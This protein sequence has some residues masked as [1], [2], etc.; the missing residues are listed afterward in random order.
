MKKTTEDLKE[1]IYIENIP[2][3]V[4]VLFNNIPEG[5]CVKKIKDIVERVI[6]P[7]EV[8]EE[9][10]YQEIGIKSH[11]KGLFYKDK[12]IGRDLG[13]KSVFWIEP[14]CLIVNIVF[15]W[16]QA[17]TRTTHK[18]KGMIASHRFP[19]YKPKNDLVNL[20]YITYFFKTSYGKHLLNLASPGGAGRNKTL[21]QKEFAEIEIP[22]P[23]SVFEQEKI[24]KILLNVDDLILKKEQYLKYK[25][26]YKEV[27]LS[28]LMLEKVR[29]SGFGDK[30][31]EVFIGDILTENKEIELDPS[32]DKRITVRLN[33]KG[34]EKRNSKSIEK[35]GATVQYRRKAGQFIYGKQNLHKGAFGIIPL[36]F[37]GYQ[38]SGDLPCFDISGIVN[39][40]WFYYYMSRENYFK[41]LIKI[42][43]G[44]GSKRIQPNEFYKLKLR[45]P[46][47]EEQ[48]KIAEILKTM[49]KEIELLEQDLNCQRELKKVLMQ[50]LL[51]G[52]T[53]V[54]Y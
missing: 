5:W 11:G 36:E 32:L 31:E 20:D 13:N 1:R 24:A 16:E 2:T 25:L 34:V 42:A 37:D 38:S 21:G 49:D 10:H 44:T 23:I 9:D 54:K 45:L 41:G 6:N 50:N 15:A 17:V 22:I 14:D 8:K 4:G 51:A 46:C 30:W 7:V 52:K 28:N 33:L 27:V 18:E 40:Y 26:Q 12:V 35:E 19:M 47:L 48:E 3:C 29:L 53:R 39:K 43:T